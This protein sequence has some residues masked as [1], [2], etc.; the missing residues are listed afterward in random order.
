ME[1]IRE[2]NST[3]RP[4]FLDGE[5]YGYWKSRME[6]IS[7]E[8]DAAIGNLRALN[9]SF[10]VVDQNVFKLINTYKSVKAAW[11]ILEVAYKGTSKVKISRL[12]ILTLR[13]EALQM[14]DDETIAEFNV[15]VLGIANK[16]DALGKR[17][18]TQNLSEKFLDLFLLSST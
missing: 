4:S 1:G 11:D 5:N 17:C 18:M 3:T 13:F 8:D 6:W 12:Q 7:E 10:N 15:R 16:S 9:A 14:T 2:G